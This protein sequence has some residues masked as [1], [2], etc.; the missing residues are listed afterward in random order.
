MMKAFGQMMVAPPLRGADFASP[1][2]KTPDQP[3]PIRTL[4][5]HYKPL[6]T[7]FINP[8]KRLAKF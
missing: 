8:K 2:K 5:T 7:F 4:Q 3:L 6:T 1:G